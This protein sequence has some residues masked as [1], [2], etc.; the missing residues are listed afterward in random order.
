M[1]AQDERNAWLLAKE[2]LE[3]GDVEKAKS[4]LPQM[5]ALYR[6]LIQQQMKAAEPHR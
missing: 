5:G 2:A 6:H 4:Y 1:N 3:R